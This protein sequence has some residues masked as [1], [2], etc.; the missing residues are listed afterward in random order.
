MVGA[1]CLSQ[2]T[3]RSGTCSCEHL[4][5]ATRGEEEKGS[6]ESR[7]EAVGNLA[8]LLKRNPLEEEI[9]TLSLAFNF[10]P[11]GL[12]PGVRLHSF[13]PPFLSELGKG[14]GDEMGREEGL[15]QSLHPCFLSERPRDLIEGLGSGRNVVF[16]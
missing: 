1:G 2:A 14:D 4:T 7:G 10:S 12:W 13:H 5:S 6:S 16:L 3:H 11:G 15:S 9:H 8:V